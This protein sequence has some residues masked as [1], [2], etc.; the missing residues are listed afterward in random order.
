M[1]ITNSGFFLV[2][3]IIFITAVPIII[4]KISMKPN[5][6]PNTNI[7]EEIRITDTEIRINDKGKTHEEIKTTHEE[8]II[9]TT[10]DDD[11]EENK[12]FSYESLMER[13]RNLE[14]EVEQTTK[15][16]TAKGAKLCVWTRCV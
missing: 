11:A 5:R 10:D 2:L 9:K 4:I 6:F 13:I 8:E 16:T 3:G 15:K 7:R 12:K 1:Q 14:S